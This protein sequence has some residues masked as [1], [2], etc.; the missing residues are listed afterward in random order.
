[1]NRTKVLSVSVAL[2]ALFGACVFAPTAEAGPPLICWPFDIGGAQSLP[3]GGPEWRATKPDYNLSKLSDD[4]LALLA[5]ATPVL[6]RMETLRRATVYAMKDPRIASELLARLQARA[7]GTE[8][9]SQPDALAL[10]DLGYLV[11]AY[12]QA[13]RTWIPGNP[14]AGLNGYVMIREAI[15]L[16]SND[17]EMEFAAALVAADGRP[18][19][20]R[21][22]HLQRAVAGAPE[23][24]LLSK[25]LLTHS[26]LV[27]VSAKTMESS[28]RK[29]KRQGH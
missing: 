10:F 4:T 11:E 15:S 13:G 16:R 25:N 22:A 2:S 19:N 29:L 17:A 23:E 27:G 24:S 6:V 9:K 26:H 18:A 5:P 28:A 1:M 3:W 21:V 7:R 14:A 8:A 12:K 20:D